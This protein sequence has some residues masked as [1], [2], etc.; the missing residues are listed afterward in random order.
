MS[1]WTDDKIIDDSFW[2]SDI[3]LLQKPFPFHT[4]MQKIRDVLNSE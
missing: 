3:V 2:D 4:L 1:G